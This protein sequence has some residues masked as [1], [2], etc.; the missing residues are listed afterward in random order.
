MPASRI[1]RHPPVFAAFV[2]A[3]ATTAATFDITRAE[4]RRS[5]RS[6]WVVYECPDGFTIHTESCRRRREAELR[7]ERAVIGDL[8]YTP[9]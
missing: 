2:A 5:G 7:F 6:L 1:P 9:N 3:V 4:A 8:T